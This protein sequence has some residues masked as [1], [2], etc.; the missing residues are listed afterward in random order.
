MGKYSMRHGRWQYTAHALSSSLKGQYMYAADQAQVHR[1]PI[2]MIVKLSHSLQ[3]AQQAYLGGHTQ[4]QSVGRSRRTP[5]YHPG[6][7]G[8]SCTGCLGKARWTASYCSH[9]MVGLL[10][11]AKFLP[12]WCQIHQANNR[13]LAAHFARRYAALGPARCWSLL[14]GPFPCSCRSPWPQSRCS[15]GSWS[16][17]RSRPPG[18]PLLCLRQP[19]AGR[20]LRGAVSIARTATML[21]RGYQHGLLL[22]KCTRTCSCPLPPGLGAFDYSVHARSLHPPA[23]LPPQMKDLRAS[24]E[25]SL[26]LL[27]DA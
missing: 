1:T 10:P 4:L 21:L 9:P 16:G 8:C 25:M 19:Q 3:A 6:Q 2:S 20:N 14:P 15:C 24:Q 11:S 23:S 13:N 5:K 26:A 27:L 12:G 18:T 22:W 17:R 7:R